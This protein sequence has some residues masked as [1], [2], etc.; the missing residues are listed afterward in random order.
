MTPDRPSDGEGN[1]YRETV[2]TYFDLIRRLR[3]GDEDAVDALMELWDED[4]LFEFAGAPPVVGSFKGAMAIRTLYKNRARSHQMGVRIGTDATQQRDLELGLVDTEVTHLRGDERRAV[5][6]WRTTIGTREGL[7]FDVAGA[8]R[9]IFT[10]EGKIASL[11]VSVSPKADE[12][13]VKDLRMEELTVTDVGRLSLA[14]W[15]VV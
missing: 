2:T 12:S 13:V 7:G 10:D 15:P 1:G 11:K 5:A 14:A 3:A 6:G 4:G 8:H 9:F